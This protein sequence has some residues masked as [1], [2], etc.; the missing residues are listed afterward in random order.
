MTND[1]N[2]H[3]LS[4]SCF[5]MF[6]QTAIIQGV[7]NCLPLGL[8]DGPFQPTHRQLARRDAEGQLREQ[9]QAQ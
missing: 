9:G 1:L 6:M 5:V 2:D 8:A 7:K 4:F 3:F